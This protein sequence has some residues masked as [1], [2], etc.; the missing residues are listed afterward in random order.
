MDQKQQRALVEKAAAVAGGLPDLAKAIGVNCGTVYRW[1]HG[2]R[3]MHM[4]SIR[5]LQEYVDRA[6]V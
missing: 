2:T 3:K 1:M 6:A 4:I 5:A